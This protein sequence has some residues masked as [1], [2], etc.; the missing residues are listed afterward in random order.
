MIISDL[1]CAAF[2]LSPPLLLA[3]E[4]GFRA[5][6]KRNTIMLVTRKERKDCHINTLGWMSATPTPTS[7]GPPLLLLLLLSYLGDFLRKRGTKMP[8][9]RINVT[10][11][12][13]RA[14]NGRR[15]EQKRA[16]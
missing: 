7:C 5:S 9:I 13:E 11:K 1:E 3:M 15:P 4:N 6:R 8:E 12:E 14:D 16:K 10:S 2:G